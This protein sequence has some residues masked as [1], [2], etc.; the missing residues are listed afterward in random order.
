MGLRLNK[1]SDAPPDGL[2]YMVPETGQVI[3]SLDKDTWLLEIKNHLR[4]NSIPIPDDLAERAEHQCCQ[5]LPPGWC[6]YSEGGEPSD[7]IDV[8]LGLDDV[9]RGTA[10]L[11]EIMA[12]RVAA[13]VNPDW[14]PFVDQATAEARAAI[15]AACY[16][17]VPVQG[18]LSCREFTA[19]AG[20]V[21]GSR[22]TK[23]DASLEIHACAICKCAA[24]SQVHIRGEILARGVDD[25]MLKRFQGV[26]HCWKT[27][28]IEE[29]RLTKD[30][31]PSSTAA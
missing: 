25:A 13:L 12:R 28:A 5:T 23:A 9:L 31:E 17:K 18:C 11:S 6:R 21:V 14:S 22:T 24:K 26:P 8:R 15:C 27:A 16:A 10:V 29:A 3:R 20:K 7:Y 4:M 19:A 30:E 2:R 1:R